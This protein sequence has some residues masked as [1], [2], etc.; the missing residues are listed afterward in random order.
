MSVGRGLATASRPVAFAI[1]TATYGLAAAV[2]VVVAA[3][4]GGHPLVRTLIADVAATVVVF[5]ISTVVDNASLYDP[6]WSVAPPIVLC[7]WLLIGGGVPARQALVLTL[8]VIWA[9]RL[10]LN[11]AMGW[12][13]LSHEDWR[14][15][16]LREQPPVPWWIVNLTGIQLMPTLVV[17]LGLLSAWP[18]M[19]VGG[20][21]L[22]WLDA[23]A[24]AVTVG[25]IMVEATADI[26]LR[27][28][29]ADPARRG[30]VADV[31]LW[32][33]SRHPNYLGEIGFW[34]GLYL[35][36][37]A[38]APSWWWTVAGPVVMVALFVGVS[39]PMMDRRSVQRRPGYGAYA[40]RVPAL[41]PRPGRR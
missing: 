4:L 16:M 30:Q 15:Q 22:G 34:W 5:A 26:Q 23:L 3:A 41:V 37:L 39:V 2:A 20:R 33:F 18:A 8:T 6:Y 7:G 27:R 29:T 35:F 40:A 38:A 19:T 13:G 24:V 1:V 32:R 21:A 9:I 12:R 28:F 25:S 14:Y 11:W 31:G 36:G 10:T 17:Y